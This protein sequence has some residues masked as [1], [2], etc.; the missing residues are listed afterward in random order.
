MLSLRQACLR[1][2]PPLSSAFIC[3]QFSV[4]YPLFA[5]KKRNMPPKKAS[6]PEKK[7]LLG[8]PGNNLKIG[9]VGLFAAY[10]ALVCSLTSLS[11]RTAKRRQVFVLQHA[12]Q[13]GYAF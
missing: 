6:Q 7:A 5:K 13:D 12:L 2:P 10:V 9:I 1:L 11:R 8:R 4:S 3:R